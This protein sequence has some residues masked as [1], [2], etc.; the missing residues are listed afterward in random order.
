MLK[1]PVSNVARRGYRD[2]GALCR[3][4]GALC[5]ALCCDLG[6]L[7]RAED[8]VILV[9]YVGQLFAMRRQLQASNLKMVRT[10]AL[11]L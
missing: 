4:L 5:R 10:A 11:G 2:L 6:A 8:I 1:C 7:C 3:D 9:P